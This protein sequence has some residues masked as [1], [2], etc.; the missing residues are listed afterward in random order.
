[1]PTE[2]A[3]GAIQVVVSGNLYNANLLGGH[4]YTDFALGNGASPRIT[5]WNG[6]N[7]VTSDSALIYDD[8]N[9]RLVVGGATLA[10]VPYPA[11]TASV[12]S[13]RSAIFAN[14]DSG[15]SALSWLT[16]ADAGSFFNVIRARGTAS[17]PGKVLSGDQLG[18]FSSRG[19]YDNGA[20]SA[21]YT[22]EVGQII[23]YADED[24]S[25]STGWGAH[26]AI[27][28]TQPTTTTLSEVLRAEYGMV[29]ITGDASVSG[30]FNVGT[31][32]G[33]AA[34]E[35]IVS[36]DFYVEVDG[37]GGG[38]FAGSLR[39]VQWYRDTGPLWRT[40]Q[41]VTIDGGLNVGAAGATAGQI[42]ATTSDAGTANAVMME[43]FTHETSNH[44]GEAAG[45]GMYFDYV[46]PVTA[47]T[48][49]SAVRVT[50]DWSNAVDANR[51]GRWTLACNNGNFNIQAGVTAGT[52]NP[53]LGFFNSN[54]V[55]VQASAANL[56][57]NV[58]SGGVNDTI[59]N[60]T[61]LTTYS[62]DA[63]AIRNDIYQLAR[64]LKQINDGLRLLGLFT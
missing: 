12:M 55:Q 30:G 61:S 33:A 14:H 40:P 20:G 43:T 27:F 45:F 44:A 52:N 17:A 28:V 31:S 25:S 47:G 18:R 60:Y 13:T 48:L 62:T 36:G 21:N 64:K 2:D 46:L 57:N 39:D 42:I 16:T 63:A 50:V 58:T 24:Y 19:Y 37:A 32:S 7:T 41:S 4:P 29:T 59:A 11:F 26:A 56:T 8:T 5:Y 10:Q 54:P 53:T 49:R 9:H 1:M 6:V 51:A 23:F 38:F 15:F 22:N 3:N 35:I 34:G